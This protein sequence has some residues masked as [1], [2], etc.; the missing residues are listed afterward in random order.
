MTRQSA[1]LPVVSALVVGCLLSGCAMFQYSVD[2]KDPATASTL[3][4]QYDQQD[5]LNLAQQMCD[6]IL[7]NPFPPAGVDKPILV[8]L[9]IQNR[10]E[11]HLDMRALADTLTTKL[12][13][14]KKIQLVDANTRDSLLKEQGYQI[15]NCA[16]DAQ[17]KIGKQLGAKYMLT[18]SLTQIDR[19]SGREVRVS[20]KQDV[21]FQLTVKVTDLETGLV[22]ASKQV[23]RLRRASKPIIGW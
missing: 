5:L 15:A 7:A 8:E 4:A 17:V 3:T 13:D 19:E 10:T 2:K 14:S 22:A 21:Y 16:P 18:G 6:S 11:D 1:I 12:L 20:K 23:D 9:G